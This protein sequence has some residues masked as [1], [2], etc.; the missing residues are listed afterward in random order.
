MGDFVAKIILWPVV[1]TLV[2]VLIVPMLISDL[3]QHKP[4]RGYE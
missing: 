4:L 3:I 2:L 1:I